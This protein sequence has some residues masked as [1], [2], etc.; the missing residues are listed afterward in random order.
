MARYRQ[1][2]VTVM[3]PHQQFPQPLALGEQVRVNDAAHAKLVFDP[4]VPRSGEIRVW[5]RV[6]DW[7]WLRPGLIRTHG[8]HE[9]PPVLWGPSA[10]VPLMT[11]ARNEDDELKVPLVRQARAS[12]VVLLT[13]R[14]SNR[15]A[16]FT[17]TQQP[18][19]LEANATPLLAVV[20]PEKV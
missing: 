20:L 17:V 8:V 18:L 6:D 5:R 15:M 19:P 14:A 4:T 9:A 10:L 2:R 13:S 12:T 16:V 7:P 3:S 11:T 1:V